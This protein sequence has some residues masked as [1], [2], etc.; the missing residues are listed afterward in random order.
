M[1]L[2]ALAKMSA[3]VTTPSPSPGVSQV[4][5]TVTIT[6]TI[7]V[8]FCFADF[9]FTQS[10]S[11]PEVSKLIRNYEANPQSVSDSA[12]SDPNHSDAILK[13]LETMGEPAL[14]ALREIRYESIPFPIATDEEVWGL[15][16]DLALLTTIRRMEGKRPPLRIDV[17]EGKRISTAIRATTRIPVKIV[18]Q[19]E[20]QQSVW[21]K[22]G[23]DYRS[24]RL[25][26]WRIQ[27]WDEHGQQVPELARKGQL[28]GGVYHVGELKF[29][30]EDT[31]CPILEHYVRIRKPGKYTA[32]ALYHNEFLI[33]DISNEKELD[34]LVLVASEKFEIEFAPGAKLRIELSREDF[35]KSKD[36]VS[37][38]TPTKTIK[39]NGSKYGPDYHSLIPPDSLQGKLLQMDQLAVPALIEELKVPNMEYKKRALILG[40]L[41]SIMHERY[42]SPSDFPG[43]IDDYYCEFPGGYCSMSTIPSREA[44]E[45]LVKEWLTFAENYI[46][47]EWSR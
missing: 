39:L 44:Q 34:N 29:G 26:R 20:G 21:Y 40:I 28:G 1:V 41:D 24:G 30:G 35:K 15:F 12:A 3:A 8:L 33:A 19:D 2:A 32:R 22:F 5:T 38:L 14:Q 43:A 13:R 31:E 47:I 6:I 25:A 9:A 7:L 4:K 36:L 10:E 45:E 16:N 23:G 46:V 42:L 27:V 18:N 11:K 37:R 17:N